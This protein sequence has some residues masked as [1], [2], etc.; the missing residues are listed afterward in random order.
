MGF[1]TDAA[2]N[3]ES[4]CDGLTNRVGMHIPLDRAS[5]MNQL[6]HSNSMVSGSVTC[7]NRNFINSKTRFTKPITS[8]AVQR[9]FVKG[10]DSTTNR[11]SP[12]SRASIGRSIQSSSI[13]T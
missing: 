6:Y 3:I 5:N 7:S 8:R 2:S 1:W 13:M 12:G 10:V 4:H 11:F 9:M